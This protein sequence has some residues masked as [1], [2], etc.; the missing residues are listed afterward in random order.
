MIKIAITEAAS[1]AIARTL[2]LGG[3][4]RTLSTGCAPCAGWGGLF[5]GHPAAGGGTP[6][7]DA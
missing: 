7:A 1:E 2:P 6:V 5:G 4:S 3:E